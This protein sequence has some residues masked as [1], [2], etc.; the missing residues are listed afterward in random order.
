MDIATTLF[1]DADPLINEIVRRAKAIVL[2]KLGFEVDLNEA[3]CLAYLPDTSMGWHNDEEAGLKDTI[4]SHSFG[5]NCNMKFA[6]KCAY[7]SGRKHISRDMVVLAR[8]DPHLPGCLRMEERRALLQGFQ[9]G[10]LTKAGCETQVKKVVEQN[11]LTREGVSPTLLSL[12]V[13]HGWYLSC[14][15]RRRRKTTSTRPNQLV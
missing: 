7:W 14:M 12:T 6:M 9:S 15:A 8:D 11:K 5:A 2:D 10:K 1:E 4:V 13:P 3:L